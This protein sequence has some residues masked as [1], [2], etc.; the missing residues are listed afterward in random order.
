[1]VI[2][3]ERL[4]LRNKKV[5]QCKIF[6]LIIRILLINHKNYQGIQLKKI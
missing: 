6:G 4:I 2:P 3:V 5:F 1:M